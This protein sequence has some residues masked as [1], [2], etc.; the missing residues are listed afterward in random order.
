MRRAYRRLARLHHPDHGGSTEQMAR[1]NAAYAAVRVC[2][3][4]NL[5]RDA[6]WERGEPSYR[7]DS[8]PR[9][10]S[11]QPPGVDDPA[12]REPLQRLAMAIGESP[13]I[14]G[15]LVVIGATLC[16]RVMAVLLGPPLDSAWFLQLWTSVTVS[17]LTWPTLDPRRRARPGGRRLDQAGATCH[18]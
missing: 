10:P 3:T 6:T 14:A 9:S 11:G 1:V 15:L 16:V 17:W 8:A 2:G 12:P 4:S 13:L 18:R 7:A 5:R